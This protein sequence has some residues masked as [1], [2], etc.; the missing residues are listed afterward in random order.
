MENSSNIDITIKVI[1][2]KTSQS[3]QAGQTNA[4]FRGHSL[5]PFIKKKKK[6]C[7]IE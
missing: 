5:V 6:V 7:C 2:K 1:Q 4:R 3:F